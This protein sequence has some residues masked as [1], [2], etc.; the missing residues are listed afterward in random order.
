MDK[1]PEG[2]RNTNGYMKNTEYSRVG[3]Q[4]GYTSR[5]FQ[6][7]S[8]EQQ[9]KNRMNNA[10]NYTRVSNN[11]NRSVA[12]YSNRRTISKPQKRSFANK[13]FK[14]ERGKL[15]LLGKV[16][17]GALT[18]S[19]VAGIGV[20]G[21]NAYDTL[22]FN[23]FVHGEDYQKIVETIG[24]NYDNSEYLQVSIP[25]EAY[26]EYTGKTLKSAIKNEPN[27]Q[28]FLREEEFNP[29]V[30]AYLLTGEVD[31]EIISNEEILGALS[32]YL[33]YAD[34][35][36]DSKEEEVLDNNIS[37]FAF[38]A[39]YC[40]SDKNK[41]N[42]VNLLDSVIG[43]SSLSNNTDALKYKIKLNEEEIERI[44]Y[45]TA[46]ELQDKI[47]TNDN[48]DKLSLGSDS[49]LYLKPY[50]EKFYNS[51]VKFVSE[52]IND[53]NTPKL[54]KNI[55]GKYDGYEKMEGVSNK[56]REIPRKAM[57]AIKIADYDEYKIYAALRNELYSKVLEEKNSP[58]EAIE[59]IEESNLLLQTRVGYQEVLER[60]DIPQYMSEVNELL[61]EIR[62]NS[63]RESQTQKEQDQI[64]EKSNRLS[65]DDFDR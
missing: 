29:E 37:N 18:I 61:E 15:N 54:L 21:K 16:A 39:E 13:V 4:Q 42:V 38:M 1:R 49:T 65:F 26:D 35:D 34:Y 41:N 25:R 62:D 40:T 56:L 55:L 33:P 14:D 31:R 44:Q 9:M 12:N 3:N 8:R 17:V 27:M 48:F 59:N 53:E 10:K 36:R 57:E 47:Y 22:K 7:I 58:E 24:D 32:D 45:N 5:N 23:A 28:D 30:W 43:E 19:T 51:R 64:K 50:V 20:T 11:I 46:N 52:K 63:Q 2:Y 6:N 60:F